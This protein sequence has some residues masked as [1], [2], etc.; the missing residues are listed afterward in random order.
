[1]LH[2]LDLHVVFFDD[3]GSLHLDAAARSVSFP[4]GVTQIHREHKTQNEV[5]SAWGGDHPALVRGVL[6][7]EMRHWLRF[8]RQAISF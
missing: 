8:C 6:E 7:P 1:M 4:G 2:T 3:N 5:L